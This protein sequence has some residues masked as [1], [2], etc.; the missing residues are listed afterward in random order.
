VIDYYLKQLEQAFNRIEYDVQSLHKGENN[1]EKDPTDGMFFFRGFIDPFIVQKHVVDLLREVW[2]INDGTR[3][4]I[5]AK[6]KAGQISLK[7]TDM[8][9]GNG[10]GK[11]IVNKHVKSCRW[12]QLCGDLANLTKH[13]KLSYATKTG[14]GPP[15][16]G[17]SVLTCQTMG[18][19]DL[20]T[21]PDGIRTIK[22]EHPVPM[23]PT[24]VVLDKNGKSIGDA[25][26]IAL[27]ARDSWYELLRRWGFT[28]ER[29]S[30]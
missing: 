4:I 22:F 11:A 12:I 20:S 10:P 28:F 7:T 18:K 29:P 27:K 26:E 2:H 25:V 23:R 15:Q 21:A 16:L 30:S 3:E 5:N 17:S 9:K 13:Y 14:D 8:D 24:M 19:M 1:W 6:W